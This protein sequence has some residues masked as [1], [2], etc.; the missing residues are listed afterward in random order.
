MWVS[1][2][3]SKQLPIDFC[4]S[5]L[6]KYKVATTHCTVICDQGELATS[7]EFNKMLVDLDFTLEVAGSGKTQNKM[8]QLRDPITHQL[9]WFIVVDEVIENA[10]INTNSIN[11]KKGEKEKQVL[12]YAK[13]V[14]IGN[15]RKTN[16]NQ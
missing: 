4:K 13:I 7:M 5:I 15:R 9:I 14:K 16:N 2:N 11:N 1:V 8:E 12:T 10:K 3:S 6:D